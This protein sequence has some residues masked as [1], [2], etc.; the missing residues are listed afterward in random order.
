MKIL[1]TYATKA[2]S[3]IQVA[4]EIARTIQSNNGHQVDVRPVES[5]RG[6]DGYDAA[7]VGSAIRAGKWLPEAQ[8][9]V[10]QH[11]AALNQM[12]VALFLVCL[13]LRED[14]QENRQTVAAYLDPVRELVKPVDVG[15]FAGVMDFT[16]LSFF[17]KL[18]VKAM[19]APQGDFRDWDAIR[20]WADA[21]AP[22]LAA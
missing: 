20:G 2:G 12:P 17:P 21:V 7:V 8:G 3:T 4:Q 5:V 13:T 6:L 22:Q 1:V 19:K 16:K 14:T 11:Q 10:E 18:I 15:L 9:F